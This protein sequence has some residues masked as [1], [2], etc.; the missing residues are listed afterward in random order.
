VSC[1]APYQITRAATNGERDPHF[2]ECLTCRRQFESEQSLRTMLASLPVPALAMPRR[3]E[4]AAELSV[5]VPAPR[6][7]RWGAYLAVACAAAALVPLFAPRAVVGEA[8]GVQ[9]ASVERIGSPGQRV[10]YETAPPLLPPPRIDAQRDARMS[11]QIGDDRELVTLVDGAIEIDA[12]DTRA[13]DVRIGA[14]LVHVADAKVE[15]RAAHRAL[16]SVHVV[17]GAAQIDNRVVVERGAIWTAEV[18]PVS[19]SL[20]AFRDAWV[21]LRAGRNEEAMSLFDAATDASVAEEASYWAAVAAQRAGDRDL[22]RFRLTS[23][24][25]SYPSSAYV[26]RAK[27]VLAGL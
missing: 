5:H 18:T 12:R 1:L 13:V 9:V 2:A 10:A 17:V 8:P 22:A 21:A 19:R 27:A 26:A 3:R 4:I 16:L 6:R 15:I 25:E 20:R 23:F 14:T 11:S 24:L 7:R